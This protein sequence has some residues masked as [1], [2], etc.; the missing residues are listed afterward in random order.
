[1][2]RRLAVA[3]LHHPVLDKEGGVVTSTLTNMDVHDLSRSA[4][5]YGCTDFFVVHPVA[6][7]RELAERIVEHW[8][9]GSSSARIPDRKDALSIVRAV[10][11]LADAMRALGDGSEVW[12]TSAQEIGT[13]LSWADARRALEGAGGPVLLVFGTSWG[14]AREVAAQ[15]DAVLPP[16]VG[17]GPWN[18]LS[19]RAACAVSLDRLRSG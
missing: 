15:A 14:L 18:H 7:Q 19:V 4:R 3:L 2:S 8:T 17:Q 6:A 13:T 16:L 10:P 9:T 11:L 1:M 5:T 12:I